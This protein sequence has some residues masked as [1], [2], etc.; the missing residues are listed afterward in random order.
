M[1]ITRYIAPVL[2][3]AGVPLLDSNGVQILYLNLE[4][5]RKMA[6]E[7]TAGARF[8]I[9]PQADVDAINAMSEA[10][11]IAHFEAVTGWTEV[12]EVEDLGTIGDS[13]DEITF[14][15]LK[16]RRVRKIKGPRN[17]GTQNVV[18][19]RDPLDD[20]QNA[21]IDAEKTDYD[22]YFKVIYDDA[23]GDSYTESVDYYAG[24]V[25][26]RQANLGNGSNVT[27]R[28]F[29]IG[30]NTGVYSVDTVGA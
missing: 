7:T 29:N 13:S 4:R 9:G 21:L 30:I 24:M 25:M 6:V 11:A 26:T 8:F 10:A 5:G 3:S 23:R 12:E 28:N 16:N 19:G 1:A 17:G 18:V 20:G 14:T 27:R 2:D 15:A 22:Y